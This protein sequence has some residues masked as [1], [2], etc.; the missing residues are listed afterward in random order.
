MPS[1]L[2][3]E[4]GKYRVVVRGEEASTG[5][6]V[7]RA[8]EGGLQRWERR[9]DQ[10]CPNHRAHSREARLHCRRAVRTAREQP[11]YVALVCALCVVAPPFTDASGAHALLA[12]HALH[13]HP[14][15]AR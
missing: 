11:V 15:A 4:V 1:L 10:L 3:L 13:D 2:S 8:D 9:D 6:D 12:A 7:G 14:R 5:W